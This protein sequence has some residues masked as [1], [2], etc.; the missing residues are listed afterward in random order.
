[1]RLGKKLGPNVKIIENKLRIVFWQ[2]QINNFF[3][4]MAQS[5][6]KVAEKASDLPFGPERNLG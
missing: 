3:Q 6:R 1:M 5:R 2:H 4:N